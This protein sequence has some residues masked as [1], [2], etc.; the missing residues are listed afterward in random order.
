MT[1]QLHAPAA[2][3]P[4]KTVTHWLRGYVNPR[5]G[6]KDI[7]K[8]KFLTLPGIEIRTLCLPASHYTA[9]LRSHTHRH[10]RTHT[11][12]HA[13]THTHTHTHT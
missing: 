12:T 11:H 10:A 6:P 1:S 2:L 4:G 13:R 3:P 9:L 8:W 5:A 7:E